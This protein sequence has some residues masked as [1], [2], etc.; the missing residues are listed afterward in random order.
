MQECEFLDFAASNLRCQGVKH[1]EDMEPGHVPSTF[2]KWWGYVFFQWKTLFPY[3]VAGSL[4]PRPQPKRNTSLT[5]PQVIQKFSYGVTPFKQSC[6]T[7]PCTAWT[8]TPPHC[9]HPYM[10]SCRSSDSGLNVQGAD[11]RSGG[12]YFAGAAA[13]RSRVCLLVAVRVGDC[14][15]TLRPTSVAFVSCFLAPIF[16]A[17]A[18]GKLLIVL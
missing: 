14:G 6:Q 7:I 13:F 4:G 2:W 1:T 8:L 16:V 15:G 12:G 18:P 11:E 10:T 9:N 3:V 5:L 17:P